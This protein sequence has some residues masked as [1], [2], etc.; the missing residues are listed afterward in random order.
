MYYAK[1]IKYKN[2]YL[3]LKYQI[4]GAPTV[5]GIVSDSGIYKKSDELSNPQLPKPVYSLKQK[6]F[7]SRLKNIKI[8]PVY[9]NLENLENID[10]S[11]KENIV[12]IKILEAD[13][14]HLEPIVKYNQNFKTNPIYFYRFRDTDGK[15]YILCSLYSYFEFLDNLTIKIEKININK[16]G[17]I[18][19]KIEEITIPEVSKDIKIEKVKESLEK[20]LVGVK[21]LETNSSALD[22]LIKL[23]KELKFKSNPIHFYRFTDTDGKVYVL[24]SMYSYFE[25]LDILYEHIEIEE[26]NINKDG[27]TTLKETNKIYHIIPKPTDMVPQSIPLHIESTEIDTPVQLIDSLKRNPYIITNN[28]GIL[29]TICMY[30]LFIGTI[31]VFVIYDNN[32]PNGYFLLSLFTEYELKQYIDVIPD[33]IKLHECRLYKQDDDIKYKL[34]TEIVDMMFDNY[35]RLKSTGNFA[36]KLMRGNTDIDN[37]LLDE[38]DP[39]LLE[40]CKKCLSV[41]DISFNTTLFLLPEKIND[42]IKHKDIL[43]I[44]KDFVEK[45]YYLSNNNKKILDWK[46]GNKDLDRIREFNF[47]DI[48]KEIEELKKKLLELEPCHQQLLVIKLNKLGFDGF[49]MQEILD[50]SALCYLDEKD[51]DK[52]L[53]YELPIQIDT[54]TKFVKQCKFNPEI[55]R[56]LDTSKNPES[57]LHKYRQTILFLI[58]DSQNEKNYSRNQLYFFVDSFHLTRV[59]TFDKIFELFGWNYNLNKL[60]FQ[61]M[62]MRDWLI[63]PIRIINI[64]YLQSP[65]S[66]EFDIKKQKF[67]GF[68][69]TRF[70]DDF[71]N[72]YTDKLLFLYYN[73]DDTSLYRLFHF[74][75]NSIHAKV[76]ILSNYKVSANE[77]NWIYYTFIMKE[78]NIPHFYEYLTE[79]NEKEIVV[80]KFSLEEIHSKYEKNC[81]D[82]SELELLTEVFY[83]FKYYKRESI[84]PIFIK[85]SLFSSKEEENKF[86]EYVLKKNNTKL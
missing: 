85:K 12:G 3:N 55:K 30:N 70:T 43:E 49:N 34:N 64:E 51:K 21:I 33:N 5:V 25:F 4:A 82:I 65:F 31:H 16:E 37:K 73:T 6:L 17:Y 78:K 19:S 7:K 11:L 68:L 77:I 45:E 52:K 79:S 23:S 57:E 74:T 42:V 27:T 86:V 66:F 63:F 67:C 47:E 35:Q 61:C 80:S 58:K 13:S 36:E 20:N 76:S 50:K 2:K 18:S 15:V 60:C 59:P 39:T 41:E 44:K 14:V 75:G 38:L 22:E 71:N 26:I 53:L 83:N 54:D 72:V 1:Y 46:Y 29:S 8:P 32:K 48:K 84:D 69:H 62:A 56:L 28:E 24:C 40:N 10:K 81:Y 9:E